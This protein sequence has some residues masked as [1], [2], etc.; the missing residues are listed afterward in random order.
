MVYIYKLY[1][2]MCMSV[3]AY[4]R[5]CGVYALPMYVRRTVRL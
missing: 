1:N 5:G 2:I 4:V 3:C